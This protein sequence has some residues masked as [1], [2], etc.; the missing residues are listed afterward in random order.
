[1]M[2]RSFTRPIATLAVLATLSALAI[3][4]PGAP[5]AGGERKQDGQ[6]Q[7]AGPG[8]PG[9]ERG[10]SGERG[11]GGERGPS[12]EGAMKGMNRA[13]KALKGQIADASKKD[14]NLQ[15]INDMQRGCIAAKGAK[16]EL[17]KDSKPASPDELAAIAKKFRAE[18]ISLARQLLALEEDIIDGKT[19]Q[20]KLK[21][22]AIVELRDKEHKEFGVKDD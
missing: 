10:R 9:G 12:V 20:A 11:P 3:A 21:L 18:M 14:E 22:D 19:D 15:L 13:L 17:P 16:F 2:P 5:G 7:P 8:G 1:M 4:Q 6:R